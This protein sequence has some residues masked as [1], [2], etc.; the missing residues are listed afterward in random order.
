MGHEVDFMPADKYESFL[1]IDR[2]T[3]DVR[4]KACTKYQK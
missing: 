1:Q 2:I 3:L 4:S